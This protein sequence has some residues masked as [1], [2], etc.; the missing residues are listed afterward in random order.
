MTTLKRRIVAIAAIA[1]LAG[2]GLA[3]G[4]ATHTVAG[5]RWENGTPTTVIPAGT[6]W[7]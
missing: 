6:R 7:E 4:A 2:A 5:T 1:T 3:A